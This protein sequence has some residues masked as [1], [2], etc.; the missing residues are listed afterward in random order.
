MVTRRNKT[1]RLLFFIGMLCLFLPIGS[2]LSANQ[3]NQH[4][5]VERP[6]KKGPTGKKR[7]IKKHRKNWVERH[8]ESIIGASITPVAG[9]II[10]LVARRKI[11]T[12]R[13]GLND[14]NKKNKALD[15]L[16]SGINRKNKNLKTE[17]L[18]LA[19]KI[20]KLE[21]INKK[22]E[23]KNSELKKK[24]EAFD[25]LQSGINGKNKDLK[26]EKLTLAN[27]IK[28][29]KTTNKEL[30]AKKSELNEKIKELQTS[31]LTLKDNLIAQQ[32]LEIEL[33]KKI[34][35]LDNLQSKVNG[36]NENLKTEK[37]NL[38]NK[39]KG[40]ETT[41]KELEAKKSE[42]NEKIKELQTSEL[43][44]KDNLIAQQTL[45]IE[46]KK[47]I[48]KF[49]TL[50][51]FRK[52]YQKFQNH[53]LVNHEMTD[54]NVKRDEHFLYDKLTGILT[55]FGRGCEEYHKENSKMDKDK[56]FRKGLKKG[57]FTACEDDIN[58]AMLYYDYFGG[59]DIIFEGNEKDGK[60]VLHY[61]VEQYS[62]GALMF[63]AS[64]LKGRK[65]RGKAVFKIKDKSGKTALET[66]EANDNQPFVLY[67]KHI[68]GANRLPLNNFDGRTTLQKFIQYLKTQRFVIVGQDEIENKDD[69]VMV[70]ATEDM[71][72][73]EDSDDSNK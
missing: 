20:K 37:L 34:E 13:L 22:L 16:Q 11:N 42:L 64:T 10:A 69:G 8:I 61:A 43:T 28:E 3:G 48:E 32:T 70:S 57:F 17:K 40:L 52:I 56:I 58:N 60:T 9:G 49:E 26:T 12:L 30:E 29:L 35:A 50:E 71:K 36:E 72:N 2:R 33:K 55:H 68:T 47:K 62:L 73:T 59:E 67:L 19:N 25:N 54:E 65:E 63:W 31:E 14:V 18:N 41:N 46:L 27:K 5:T 7:K 53:P 1:T 44:L 66:A 6:A 45:E 4:V 21:T 39:I 51:L 15:N 24:T 38:I 23:A